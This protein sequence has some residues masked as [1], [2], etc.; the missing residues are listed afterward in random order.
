MNKKNNSGLENIDFDNA[1]KIYISQTSTGFVC[2]IS[3]KVNIQSESMG[4]VMTLARGMMKLVLENPD[5][6]FDEG[7][8]DL[9]LL[10]KET[11]IDFQTFLKHRRSKLN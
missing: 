1:I 3:D 9:D 2:G 7:M 5:L 8:R 6:V 11:E 10:S 4:I